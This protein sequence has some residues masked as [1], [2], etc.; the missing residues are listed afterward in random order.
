MAHPGNEHFLPPPCATQKPP[1][2][3]TL[4]QSAWEQDL[5]ARLALLELELEPLRGVPA[6]DAGVEGVGAMLEATKR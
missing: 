2:A 4:A 1:P 3:S 6:A 5:R